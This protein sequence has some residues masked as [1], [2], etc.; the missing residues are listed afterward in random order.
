MAD[1]QT[2]FGNIVIVAPYWGDPQ[3]LGSVRVE[4]YLRWLS[5]AGVSVV[6][7]SGG[8]HDDLQHEAWGTWVRVRDPLGQYRGAGPGEPRLSPP[9]RRFLRWLAYALLCPDPGIAWGWRVLRQPIVAAL[10]KDAQLVL[11]SSFPESAHVVASRLAK[12]SK[13][14]L[15]VDMRDGWLDEPMKP[16]LRASPFRRLREGMQE[17]R[18]LRQAA[19]VLVTSK[20]WQQLLEQRLRFT[21]GKAVTL[22][23]AYPSGCSKTVESKPA[24][25]PS[26]RPLALLYAGRLY[27]S[28]AER[29][30]EHLMEP[31][32]AGL[33]TAMV[34]GTVQF[35]G[36]LSRDELHELES[37]QD[38][39]RKVGWTIAVFPEVA[40]AEAL[41]LMRQADGL[42]L[43]S[44]SYASIPAKLFDYLCAQRPILAL[45]R[46]GSA[47][48][49]LAPNVRQMFI[50]D[51]MQPATPPTVSG[52]IEACRDGCVCDLPE[53]FEE[54]YLRE[55]F[56][57]AVLQD[58]NE[59]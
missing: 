44:S 58:M 3:H 34:A 40:R 2:R 5:S 38:D 52:F 8:E 35:V 29:K 46:H 19:S 59:P 25:R 23:N 18:I 21:V 48:A 30:V 7:I 43:L 12:R 24:Q 41:D 9:R 57:A 11:S 1:G 31:L 15:V 51:Y 13:A 28:R 10:C 16:F 56:Y 6:I 14:R 20:R 27:T 55:V 54:T 22:T 37:W 39:F 50:L 17:H 33:K 53:Q 32:L 36:N 47:V 49:D 26:G 45:A 42:L 4:R